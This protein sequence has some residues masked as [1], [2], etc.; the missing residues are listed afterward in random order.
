[1]IGQ[2]SRDERTGLKSVQGAL[3]AVVRVQ[4]AVR[5][6]WDLSL[7]GWSHETRVC[8]SCLRKKP[9]QIQGNELWWMLVVGVPIPWFHACGGDGPCLPGSEPHGTWQWEN[10]SKLIYTTIQRK[11]RRESFGPHIP[12]WR[13]CQGHTP[14][15]SIRFQDEATLACCEDIG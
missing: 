12:G 8:L 1:M 9:F 2:R 15:A 7:L 4:T 3:R 11:L 5:N 6:F 13:C 14:V 10:W